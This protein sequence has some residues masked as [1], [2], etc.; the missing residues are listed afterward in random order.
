MGE[1]I[2]IISTAW[3]FC[4]RR[5]EGDVGCII[6]GWL[7]YLFSQRTMLDVGILRFRFVQS[8]SLN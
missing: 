3:S 5:C 7:W 4:M 2:S 1:H 6:W 8:L